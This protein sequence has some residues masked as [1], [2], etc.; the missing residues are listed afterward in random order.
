MNPP[1]IPVLAVSLAAFLCG[2]PAGEAR[3]SIGESR[4]LTLT[5]LFDNYPFH[6]GCETGWG[7][8]ALIEGLDRTILFDT[9]ARGDILLK[10]IEALKIDPSRIDLIVI[11]HAHWDHTGGLAAILRKKPGLPVYAPSSA[12]LALEAAVKEAG[13]RIIAVKEPRALFPGAMV[14]GELGEAIREQALVLDTSRGLVVVTGCSHPGIIPILEKAKEIRQQDLWTVLGGFHLMRT[15]PLDIAK[16]ITRF[17]ELGV[18]HVGASHCTGDA[19]I[20]MF[21]KS[22]GQDFVELGVG[23]RIEFGSR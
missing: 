23:R 6:E 14:T 21:R 1:R 10:N 16:I 17:K 7:F 5:V 15:P 11:S 13:G 18:R 22:Y 2:H 19:A 4:S 20:E 12:N 8:A 9:G 3:P